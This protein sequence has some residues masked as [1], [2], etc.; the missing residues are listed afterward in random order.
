MV[1]QF[2]V[3]I[4]RLSFDGPWISMHFDLFKYQGL[5]PRRAQAFL[6]VF[7]AQGL[8]EEGDA[9]EWVRESGVI[10]CKDISCLVNVRT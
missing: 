9:S 7:C 1:K 3:Y 6:D 4:W 2:D 5:I 10:H 8:G